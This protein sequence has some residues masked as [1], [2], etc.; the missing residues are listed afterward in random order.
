MTIGEL[1]QFNIMISYLTFPILALGWMMS[2]IQEGISA[3]GRINYILDQPV[4]NLERKTPLETDQ[5]EFVIK[6]LSYSYPGHQGEVLRGIDLTIP[7]GQI[8]GITGKVGSGKSTLLNILTGLLKPEP[9]H[10]FVNG[11]DICDIEPRSLY[12]RIAIVSQSPF[13][14]SRSVAENIALG[15]GDILGN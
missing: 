2:L 8:I 1:L 9:G 13:L 4:E 11:I 15:P 6:N 12:D 3:M 7:A 10:V 5:P 14:F